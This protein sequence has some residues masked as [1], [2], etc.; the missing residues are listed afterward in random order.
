M[1]LRLHASLSYMTSLKNRDSQLKLLRK[2]SA[3]HCWDQ[4]PFIINFNGEMFY[5]EVSVHGHRLHC[6]ES[7]ESESIMAERHTREKLLRQLMEGG[8]LRE[9]EEGAKTKYSPQEHALGNLLPPTMPYLPTVCTS[10]SSPFTYQ[11][12]KTTHE[13]NAP[14]SNHFPQSP[15]PGHYC[16][17]EM[18]SIPELLKDILD[19]NYNK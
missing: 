5:F 17:G 15:T 3:C 9:R 19:T 16:T 10:M 7:E 13:L 4:I 14:E 8:K 6:S 11:M 12:D 18:S 1:E 2:Q